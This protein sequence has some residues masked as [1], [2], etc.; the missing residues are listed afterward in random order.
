MKLL[1]IVS[2]FRVVDGLCSCPKLLGVTLDADDLCRFEAGDY[3]TTT[4]TITTTATINEIERR[5]NTEN[6]QGF[7]E[8]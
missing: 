2:S 4:V 6:N 5:N 8:L 3:S 1:K 7:S